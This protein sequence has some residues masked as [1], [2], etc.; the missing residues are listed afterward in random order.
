MEYHKNLLTYNWHYNIK[1]RVSNAIRD[2][3]SSHYNSLSSLYIIFIIINKV[4][5]I[6]S[7]IEDIPNDYD[8]K[9]KS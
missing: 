9:I 6:E 7:N 4:N 5:R 8:R 3:S 1:M 2:R